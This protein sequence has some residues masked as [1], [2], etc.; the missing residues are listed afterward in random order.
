MG[1]A[2]IL[3]QDLR[4]D[5]G[6][7]TQLNTYFM[8][9]AFVSWDPTREQPQERN[10]SWH[11]LAGNTLRVRKTHEGER[12]SPDG[13]YETK[14]V[15]P[16]EKQG[17][18]RY[19]QSW[20]TEKDKLGFVHLALPRNF[21]PSASSLTGHFP[22]YVKFDRG[23]ICLDWFAIH[24]EPTNFTFE[25][26]QCANEEFERKGGEFVEE[27]R[28]L[29]EITE[30]EKEAAIGFGAGSN[31]EEKKS[32]DPNEGWLR[33][34]SLVVGFIAGV[35]ALIP[36]ASSLFGPF[37]YAAE[38]LLVI[39]SL[40]II[41]FGVSLLRSKPSPDKP[42]NLPR[43]LGWL[44]ILGAPVL[45][46]LL[47]FFFLR[48][49]SERRQYVEREVALGDAELNVLHNPAKA[50]EH[51]GNALLAAPRLGSIRAK[52]QDAQERR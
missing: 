25:L 28:S 3:A 6:A 34:I 49:P 30:K 41:F 42:R 17:T 19:S 31:G 7:F 26:V 52:M 51:Y 37:D 38:T 18:F 46:V 47:W 13:H 39:C 10:E 36:Q 23:R 12:V 20:N 50:R 4:F 22:F 5:A 11:W 40:G 35:L 48:L 32:K 14:P 9:R 27:A 44:L 16:T 21:C 43:R 1:V 15:Q 33:T 24:G 45:T 29:Q 8:R 2:Y